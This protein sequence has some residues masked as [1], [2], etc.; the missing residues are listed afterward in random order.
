M[1]RVKDT[2]LLPYRYTPSGSTV[3]VLLHLQ[4]C[5]RWEPIILKMWVKSKFVLWQPCY[6]NLLTEKKK[7]NSRLWSTHFFWKCR[8]FFTATLKNFSSNT[9]FRWYTFGKFYIVKLNYFSGRPNKGRERFWNL[10]NWPLC[11]WYWQ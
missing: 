2:L 9:I 3:S 8:F 11:W 10:S 7:K 6:Y 5:H 4:Y 1:D